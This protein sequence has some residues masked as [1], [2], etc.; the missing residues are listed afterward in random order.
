M[1]NESRVPRIALGG[2]IMKSKIL[3]WIAIVWGGLVLLSG[4]TK[5]LSGGVGRGAYG[6][7][8]LT[9]FLFGGILCSVGIYTLCKKPKV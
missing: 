8:Q 3:G 9:G 6:A 1:R 4:L 5:L 2:E 7:G